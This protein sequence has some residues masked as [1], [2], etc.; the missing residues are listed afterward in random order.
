MSC[1]T[2]FIHLLF[3]NILMLR[4]LELMARM[5]LLSPRMTLMW[6]DRGVK[7]ENQAWCKHMVHEAPESMSHL[8][9]RLHWWSSAFIL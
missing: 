1:R 8:C 5:V 2:E 4:Q 7:W 9:Y 3:A 6:Q